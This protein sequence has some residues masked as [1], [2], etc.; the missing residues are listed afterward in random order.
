MVNADQ[1]AAG[2]FVGNEHRFP[3][4]I[5]FEDTDLAGIVYYAN[6]LRYMERARS[7]MMGLVGIDQRA[8]HERGEGAYVVAEAHLR[9]RR[10]ARLDDALLI[11]SRVTRVRPAT[12]AIHQRVMRGDETLVEGDV[13]AAFVSGDGRAVRQPRAWVDLFTGLVGE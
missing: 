7:D 4:R 10:P 3:L 13:I 8:A 6:Y 1:P 2:R 11:R 5:Y 9:Y 12:T